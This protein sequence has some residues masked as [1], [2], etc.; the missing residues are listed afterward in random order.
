MTTPLWK[1]ALSFTQQKPKTLPFRSEVGALHSQNQRHCL[2]EASSKLYTTKIKDIEDQTLEA[3]S[4]L[5][6]TKTKDTPFRKRALS[7]TQ[8]KPKTLP[9]GSKLRALHN[10]NQRHWGPNLGGFLIKYTSSLV[11]K[12]CALRNKKIS[13][14]NSQGGSACSC[15]QHHWFHLVACNCISAYQQTT[16]RVALRAPAHNIPDF[17]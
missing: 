4:E 16:A 11:Q 9:F 15:T 2:S 14:N 6:T 5:Y 8:Q 10:K 7:F 1:R 17:I 12:W 13:A 3:S